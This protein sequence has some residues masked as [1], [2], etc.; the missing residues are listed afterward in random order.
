[1]TSLERAL[2]LQ[3]QL[4]DS[5]IDYEDKENEMSASPFVAVFGRIA[6]FW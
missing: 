2:G 6:I 1:M 5:T 4:Q 3:V